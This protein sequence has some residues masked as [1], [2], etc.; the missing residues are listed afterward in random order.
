M[1]YEFIYY[2]IETYD[3]SGLDETNPGPHFWYAV[4]QTSDGVNYRFTDAH[5]MWLWMVDRQSTDTVVFAVAH[6]GLGYDA[7]QLAFEVERVDKEWNTRAGRSEERRVG[8]ECRSRWS[9]Y[10]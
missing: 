9:P 4:A 7:P 5:Q 8:K 6:N 2:D 10:H 3:P 1:H